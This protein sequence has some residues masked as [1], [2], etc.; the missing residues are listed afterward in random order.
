M[1]VQLSERQYFHAL[2]SIT[3]LPE[4]EDLVHLTSSEATSTQTLNSVSGAQLSLNSKGR[5]KTYDL[6]DEDEFLTT[7]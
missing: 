4:A 2:P 1:Q 7:E 3:S 5:L 6:V